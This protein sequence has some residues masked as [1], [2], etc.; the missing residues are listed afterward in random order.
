MF[1]IYVH[2]GLNNKLIPLISLLRIAR[3]EN[4]KINCY[5]GNDAYLSKSIFSFLD[6]FE[7]IKDINFINFNEFDRQFKNQKNIIYNK[8]G[9]DRDRKEIIYHSKENSSVFY[10]IVHLISFTDDNVINNFVPYPRE[11][12]KSNVFINELQIIIKELKPQKFIIKK[13]NYLVNFIKNNLVIGLHIRTTDGGFKD[14]EFKN[15]FSIIEEYIKKKYIIYISCDNLKNENILRTKYKKNIKFF[16]K[17]YGKK[18]EDKFNRST[19][20]TL[21]AICE[22]YILSECKYFFGTPG[23]S[24]S[25]MVWLLRNDEELN[26]WCKNPW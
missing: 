20:G 4:K 1:Y 19:Y 7:P 25:F 2:S 11:K 10:K 22:M 12:I 18:Y 16:D 8:K 3:K 23:S 5:W 21:N 26:F 13:I 9:S 17:P 14:I 15:S 24:F 6:L